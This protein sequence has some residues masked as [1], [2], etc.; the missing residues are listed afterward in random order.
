MWF[1]LKRT[2]GPYYVPSTV[3]DPGN[4]KLI[5]SRVYEE[6]EGRLMI[7]MT[8]CRKLE[9]PRHGWRKGQTRRLHVQKPKGTCSPA[10]VGERNS[11]NTAKSHFQ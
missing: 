10:I 9:G 7:G 3:L 4:K 11:R 6:V 2:T 5:D 8:L 1:S